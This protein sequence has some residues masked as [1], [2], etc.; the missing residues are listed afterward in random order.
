M[1]N[2][3]SILDNFKDDFCAIFE[4]YQY[5]IDNLQN[6]FFWIESYTGFS[7][8]KVNKENIWVQKNN[9]LV[10]DISKVSKIVRGS[11][12]EEIIWKDDRNIIFINYNILETL[13]IENIDRLINEIKTLIANYDI[14]KV[15]EIEKKYYVN[16]ESVFK[17]IEKYLEEQ[18]DYS[19]N[20]EKEIKQIDYYYDTDNSDLQNHNSTLRI[21]NKGDI[22]ELTIKRPVEDQSD[23]NDQN[24]RFE[25]QKQIKVN[26]IETEFDFIYEHLDFLDKKDVIKP[27]LTIHNTRTPI[28]LKKK[29]ILFEMVFDRVI[30]ENNEVSS[31]SDYQIEIELKSDY[32]HSVNLKLFTDDIERNIEG[33]KS[34]HESKYLRGISV[35]NGN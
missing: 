10:V 23:D 24:K 35:L 3:D 33:L 27:S 8:Y 2:S 30:Y 11:E 14:R 15:I 18:K 5:H 16:D 4:R 31:V 25:F 19:I 13:H 28:I 22:C 20:I 6:E 21:R 1:D 12:G 34:T 17:D 9:G 32:P 26:S 7:A 29:S